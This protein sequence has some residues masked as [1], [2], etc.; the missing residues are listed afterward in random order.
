MKHFGVIGAGILGVIAMTDSSMAHG[1]VIQT[2]A[3]PTVEV[4]GRYED[5]RPLKQAQVKVFDP[6]NPEQPKFNGI[7]DDQGIYRFTPTVPGEWS[8]FLRQAGHGGEITV[9]IEQINANGL[10]IAETST[11]QSWPQ[12]I[13][14]IGSVLWGCVGTALYFRGRSA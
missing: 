4:Q 10:T 1:V 11:G 14:M 8:I 2:K 7:T 13:I 5:G 9:P 3:R 12:R 6:S